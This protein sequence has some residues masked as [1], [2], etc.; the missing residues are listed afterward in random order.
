[1]SNDLTHRLSAFTQLVA[2]QQT[3]DDLPDDV[4]SIHAETLR[5]VY[6]D[7]LSASPSLTEQ[8]R[9][10]APHALDSF[11][12]RD[13]ANIDGLDV[14]WHPSAT[15]RV[16]RWLPLAQIPEPLRSRCHRTIIEGQRL[17]AVFVDPVTLGWRT[18]ENILPL[19][20]FFDRAEL[21]MSA[22]PAT[23]GANTE[24]YTF[25][26][27]PDESSRRRLIALDTLELYARPLN[28]A[29]R[30]G[31]RFIFH[32]NKL[33]AALEG[34]VRQALPDELL[35]GFSHVNPVLRLNR[36]EP[37]D[38]PFSRHL[39]T[40]YYD[41]SLGHV[42]RYTLLLYLTQ[43]SAT[44]ALELDGTSFD[45]LD[46]FQC[47][48]FHQSL[49][50]AGRPF[51][52]DA[53]VFLRTELIFTE[54]DLQHDERLTR[55]FTRACYAS[56]QELFNQTQYAH[57][58]D[59]YDRAARAHWGDTD[60]LEARG[61]EMFWD[62]E[63]WTG[64]GLEAHYITNGYDY[65]FRK[66]PR[67]D[68]KQ[69]AALA[70]Y[71]FFGPDK[72]YADFYT[73]PLPIERAGPAD[74]TWIPASLKDQSDEMCA[75]PLFEQLP[76]ELLFPPAEA[77]DTSLCCPVCDP[78]TF[79]AARSEDVIK[80]YVRMQQE[81][82]GDL[83]ASCLFALAGEL[84]I[85]PANF[86][87]QGDKIHVLSS[88]RL[89]PIN[90]AAYNWECWR[91]KKPGDYVYYDLSFAG[92]D[93]LVPPIQWREVDGCYH[94]MLHIFQNTW[95]TKNDYRWGLAPRIITEP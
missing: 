51:D 95:T 32:A 56:A 34:A 5:D 77:P 60:A 81:A 13:T 17:G 38:P 93:A 57:T 39:D 3:I 91:S 35:E 50:H 65:W 27:T 24:V 49:P 90:F 31:K 63:I 73:S 66:D 82:R 37:G 68:L 62:K 64:R 86:I 89:A 23:R 54:R 88:Q 14:S 85:N 10:S 30:G 59:C 70:L 40:P 48:I 53:K 4:H 75:S 79:I 2:R 67:L 6:F 94:L 1:M 78:D 92:L 84:H 42:S 28:P 9:A 71:D 61:D 11:F 22:A 36:F 19:G 20:H 76:I 46:T 87:I 44:G 45:T 15:H 8:E 41:P 80:E 43:G 7:R 25:T 58:Q 21:D 29:T 83:E 33:A 69:C 74:M 16:A 18:F 12:A 26:L 55:L 72:E 52:D 47:V